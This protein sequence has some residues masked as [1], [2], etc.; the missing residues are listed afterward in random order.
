M[1]NKLNSEP[2]ELTSQSKSVS[3]QN[4]QTVHSIKFVRNNTNDT[5]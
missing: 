1:S 4:T 2:S 5:F 3:S